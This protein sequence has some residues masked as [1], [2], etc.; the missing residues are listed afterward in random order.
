MLCPSSSIA[1][2][3]VPPATGVVFDPPGIDGTIGSLPYSFMQTFVQPPLS[4]NFTVQLNAFISPDPKV[5]TSLSGALGANSGF[6]SALL[7]QYY[8]EA[9]G[10]G[11]Q[12]TPVSV[13]FSVAWSVEASP[14]GQTGVGAYG[15][16]DFLLLNGNQSPFTFPAIFA[17][18]YLCESSN[19]GILSPVE[20]AQMITP[21]TQCGLGSVL[22]NATLD[23]NTLYSFVMYAGAGVGCGAA[24][25][26]ASASSV[27]DPS[28]YI[29]P[30]TP[31]AADYSI[32]LSDGVGN[33]PPI[34]A[35]EPGAN[36]LLLLGM[37]FVLAI[38][39]RAGEGPSRASQS[40]WRIVAPSRGLPP[41][42]ILR[43][44]H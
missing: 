8:F 13:D 37:A 34:S 26:A 20:Q 31:G 35:P 22:L 4:P 11:A 1:D 38:R 6:P 19:L 21:S 7:L 43:V 17:Q 12:P 29:D 39:K 44:H 28:I 24:D 25:C 32:L 40:H 23:T 16:A 3:L 2:G 27:V 15:N 5:S 14:Q 41:H 33:P 18:G 9:V 36:G 30:T 42:F 10:G